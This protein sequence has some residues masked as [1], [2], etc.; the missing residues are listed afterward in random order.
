M[1]NIPEIFQIT[2]W[3]P[4]NIGFGPIKNKESQRS[5]VTAPK[6]LP[7]GQSSLQTTLT[8]QKTLKRLH[9]KLGYILEQHEGVNHVDPHKH[10]KNN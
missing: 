1:R 3:W 10:S 5:T 9:A 6:L 8:Q 2:I 7:P 4:V